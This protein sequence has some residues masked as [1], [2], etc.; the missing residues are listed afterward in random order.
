LTG[1]YSSIFVATPFLAVL[2]ERE[3][4]YSALRQKLA[5][6]A[7]T[8]AAPAHA[9]TPGGGGAG[10]RVADAPEDE[11]AATEKPGSGGPP[12]VAPRPVPTRRPGAT[13]PR[14][15]QKRRRR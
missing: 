3:P 5:G 13:A 14:P 9:G 11:A 8:V 15:R 10:G 4:R 1:A 7:S 6:R 12:R 2:K